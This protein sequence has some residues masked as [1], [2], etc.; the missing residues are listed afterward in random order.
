MQYHRSFATL[1]LFWT[2]T[3]LAL[4]FA[5]DASGLD[6]ALARLSADARGFPLRDHWLLSGLLH[7]GARRA[8]WLPFLWLLVGIWKPTGL[9][10]RLERGQRIQWAAA[11]LVALAVVSSLK[12]ISHTSCPWDLADFGG[13]AAWISHW[14]LGVYD[15]GPGR[16]FPAGH[17]SAGFAFIAA[18]FVLRG[19]FPWQAR[20]WL[21][22]A[23]AVGLL[24]GAVQQ[25][26]GAHFMSHTLW[27]AWLCWTV[28]WLAA[29]VARPFTPRSPRTPALP[30]EPGPAS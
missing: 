12:Q 30:V 19:Q 2:L 25:L 6:L 28:G 22:T 9:L 20:A 26:R 7:E 11:T 17:A 10:R 3:G 5:W 18:Y 24:L 29:C 16:C 15:G 1:G 23:I 8:A 21:G 13:R 27:T 4:L 14:A